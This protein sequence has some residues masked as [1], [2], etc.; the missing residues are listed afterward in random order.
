[1][2]RRRAGR[3]TATRDAAKPENASCGIHRTKAPGHQ[4]LRRYRACDR[5]AASLVGAARRRLRRGRRAGPRDARRS[6]RRGDGA[7]PGRSAWPAGASLAARA[8]PQRQEPA[9]LA[10]VSRHGGGGAGELCAAGSG[11]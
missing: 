1:M 11:G 7:V 2:A 8:A 5:R 10:A 4:P 3:V 6:L 9:L